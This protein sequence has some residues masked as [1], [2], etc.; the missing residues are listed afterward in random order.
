MYIM[1]EFI[2]CENVD[3]ETRGAFEAF[4]KTI[5][6]YFGDW[7][8]ESTELKLSRARFESSYENHDNYDV[9]LFFEATNGTLLENDVFEYYSKILGCKNG[10]TIEIRENPLDES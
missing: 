9:A 8:D 4:F 1:V 10:W 2:D 7:R 3:H 5:E 6:G